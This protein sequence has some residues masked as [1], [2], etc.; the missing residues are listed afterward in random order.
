MFP[1]EFCQK[2]AHV[3]FVLQAAHCAACLSAIATT[4]SALADRGR[5][6]EPH[7]GRV[8]PPSQSEVSISQHMI[9]HVIV[10]KLA[11][12]LNQ[13]CDSAV[14]RPEKSEARPT[15]RCFDLSMSRML[16]ARSWQSFPTTP[17]IAE[18]AGT[19]SHRNSCHRRVPTG[20]GGRTRTWRE[21]YSDASC[22]WKRLPA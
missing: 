11:I 19:N 1:L 8:K 20:G 16:F 6:W 15:S 17:V 14:C 18:G 7:D 21:C 10:E 9:L 5:V 3:W 22:H 12:Q 4:L 13:L 2:R